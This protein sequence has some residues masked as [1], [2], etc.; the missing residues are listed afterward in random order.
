MFL[1]K[2]MLL[3]EASLESQVSINAKKNVRERILTL[4][5]SQKEEERFVKSLVIWDKLLRKPEFQHARTIL[6]YA[7]FDGEVDTFE[8][9]KHAQ[10]LGKRIGLPYVVR[11]T[12]EIIPVLVESI[13]NDLALGPYGVRQPKRLDSAQRLGPEEIDLVIVPA[14]AFDRR[15]NR[16]GRGAGYYDR[17]LKGLPSDTPI[18]GLAFDFQIVDQLSPQEEHDVPVS[19]VL[20]N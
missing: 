17:F 6:F 19:C 1:M 2:D 18:I 13:E 11:D 15:N 7:S 20:V 16:L 9:M 14:V 10:K 3:T 4:L 8:M 12:R 5:R